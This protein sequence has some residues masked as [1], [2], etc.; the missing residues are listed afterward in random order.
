MKRSL[1]GILALGAVFGSY[2]WWQ[3]DQD[4][5]RAGAQWLEEEAELVADYGE[6]LQRLNIPD[7]SLYI[8]GLR[9]LERLNRAV[10]G[11]RYVSSYQAERAVDN[12]F[13]PS[14]YV[15]KPSSTRSAL[16]SFLAQWNQERGVG[17]LVRRHPDRYLERLNI[18]LR[19]LLRGYSQD[20]R[21][22]AIEVLVEAGFRDDELKGYLTEL[23]REFQQSRLHRGGGW[24]HEPLPSFS[25]VPRIKEIAS[26]AGWNIDAVGEPR[27]LRIGRGQEGAVG[28]APYVLHK[29][30]TAGHGTGLQERFQWLDRGG[31][32]YLTA[33]GNYLHVRD[34]DNGELLKS[35]YRRFRD[36][37][38]PVHAGH[39]VFT[40][41]ESITLARLPDAEPIKVLRYLDL[42]E[43]PDDDEGLDALYRGKAIHIDATADGSIM[44][45]I[46]EGRLWLIRE[47]FD[48]IQTVDLSWENVGLAAV[49]FRLSNDGATVHC[50][51]SKSFRGQSP[52]PSYLLSIDTATGAV[53]AGRELCKKGAHVRRMAF[54]A[55]GE[56]LVFTT[57]DRRNPDSSELR[58]HGLNDLSM[59]A[60]IPLPAGVGS[61]PLLPGVDGTT[62]WILANQQSYR[63]D[64]RSLQLQP[65]A[66]K[67][68]RRYVSGRMREVVGLGGESAVSVVNGR[69]SITAA[70]SKSAAADVPH[71]FFGLTKTGGRDAICAGFSGNR[72]GCIDLEN[73]QLLADYT[74]SEKPTRLRAFPSRSSGIVAVRGSQRGL[75][76]DTGTNEVTGLDPQPLGISADGKMLL[77]S[78]GVIRRSDG[79]CVMRF[80]VPYKFDDSRRAPGYRFFGYNSYLWGGRGIAEMRVGDHWINPLLGHPPAPRSSRF[81]FHRGHLFIG[82][83]R[84]WVRQA[85]SFSAAD[86]CLDRASNTVAYSVGGDIFIH[87]LEQQRAICSLSVHL[88]HGQNARPI[89]LIEALSGERLVTA[90]LDG[91]AFVWDLAKIK[92]DAAKLQ[93]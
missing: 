60:A 72:V 90:G 78:K 10:D 71:A 2:L 65:S 61:W 9:G 73:G 23:E 22:A 21:M 14:S 68:E 4:R 50:V 82:G 39:F 45:M 28:M 43:G 40:A 85:I 32:F 18:R 11:A 93:N 49:A 51:A 69:Y 83:E 87:C 67:P 46:C 31:E 70:G 19:R 12:R 58:C 25:P 59:K 84:D 42:S 7:E 80:T 64:I 36:N 15:D 41:S 20:M 77:V 3:W 17:G 62:V 54:T 33:S 88:G 66:L 16:D 55:D 47:H 34:A 29:F 27:L 13:I 37:H 52:Y 1:I 48:V 74:L 53:S 38:R 57:Y 24:K 89:A 79:H 35:I 86:I 76:W 92:A 81:Y 26:K 5:S 63:F 6:F 30:G 44:A 56:A 91:Q 8:P 75:L